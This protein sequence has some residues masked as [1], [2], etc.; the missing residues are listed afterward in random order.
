MDDLK[1]KIIRLK[2]K[3]PKN[4]RLKLI[5]MDDIQ[6][7]PNGTFGTVLGV[8][9]IGMILVKWDNGS[10]LSLIPEEDKFKIVRQ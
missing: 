7:P 3:F 8:D 1:R 5:S 6:A 2:E 4:T 10:T 9:D